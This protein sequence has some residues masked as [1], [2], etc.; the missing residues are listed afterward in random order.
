MN[1]RDVETANGRAD[2]TIR[3]RGER[4]M[5]FGFVARYLIH[6]LNFIEI[7]WKLAGDAAVETSLQI[8]CPV[9][10]ENV[11]AAGVLL[12]NASNT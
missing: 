8:R 6:R 4:C 2:Q 11:F 3:A 12:A 1:F 10:T 5:K 9:L 7:K